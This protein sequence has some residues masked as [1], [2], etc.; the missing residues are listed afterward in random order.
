MP[1][2]TRSVDCELLVID[3]NS[4]TILDSYLLNEGSVSRLSSKGRDI[5]VVTMTKLVRLHWDG[6]SLVRDETF[7]ATYVT[8]A[9]QEFAWDPVITKSDVWMLDNGAGSQNYTK[10]LLGIGDAKTS[11]K[12]IRVS[13]SDGSLTNYSVNDQVNS[14]VSNPPCID[15]ERQVAIGYDSAHGVVSAFAFDNSSTPLWSKQLNHAMHP[16]L[17]K[18]EGIVMMNDYRVETGLEDIVLLDVMTGEELHRVTTESPLQSV[19]FGSCGF[20]NDLYVCSF[21]H[22]SRISF[23][24]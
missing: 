2:T 1:S 10:S 11:Q 6:T 9:G 13:L 12:L 16:I 24:S 20:S 14:L 8:E 21:S 19:I 22:V 4:L 15:E 3:P 7:S 23:T 17:L 18:E 5:Y